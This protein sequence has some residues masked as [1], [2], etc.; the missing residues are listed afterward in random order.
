MYLA[1]VLKQQEGLAHDAGRGV[2]RRGESWA[3]RLFARRGL[4]VEY[5]F[6][7]ARLTR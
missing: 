6:I 7:A 4:F 2:R 1:T 5:A 3:F